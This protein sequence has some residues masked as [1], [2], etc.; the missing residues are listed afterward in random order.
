MEGSGGA[1]LSLGG[2]FPSFAEVVRS[3]G[4]VK[5]RCPPVERRELE[6]ILAVRL[7][8]SEARLALDCSELDKE[9]L[10]KDRLLILQ[11]QQSKGCCANIYLNK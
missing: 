9:L 11:R 10:G 6:F 7:A 4:P 2:A 5:M 3:E 1:W 8:D